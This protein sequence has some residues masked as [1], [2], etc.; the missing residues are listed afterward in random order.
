MN[1]KILQTPEQLTQLIEESKS[2]QLRGVAI[3]KHSTRCPI[4]ALAKSRLEDNWC[5]DENELP[6]YYLDLI[7]FRDLSNRIADDFNV[8]HE[9]PQLLLINNGK[10]FYNASHTGIS[11]K[12]VE[13]AL[14]GNG[15]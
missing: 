8:Q 1:W 13:S 4:S 15:S 10:C 6:I 12:G 14:R 11:A 2:E 9:S 3:F 5:F 7:S